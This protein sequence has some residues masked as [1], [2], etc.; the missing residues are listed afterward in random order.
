MRYH[1]SVFFA[2]MAVSTAA[3]PCDVVIIGTQKVDVAKDI[4]RR[5]DV[6]VRATAAEY[7]VPPEPGKRPYGEVRFNV[8]ESIRGTPPSE[9]ILK[10]ELVDRD[11]FNPRKAPYE[12]ARPNGL[13]GTCYAWQYR[14]GAQYLLLLK[15][16]DSGELTAEWDALSPTNEQLH[17]ADDPWLIWVRAQ[18]RRH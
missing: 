8:I 11:D 4:V 5:A 2:F 12:V 3:Y 6:I 14:T 13:R 10:G 15:R 9:L 16:T 7:T 18:S 17:S 1:A